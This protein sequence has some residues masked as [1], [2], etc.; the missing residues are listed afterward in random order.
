[1]RTTS[2]R[3]L[4]LLAGSALVV[5]LGTAGPAVADP[6]G[7]IIPVDCDGTTYM[8]AVS[9]NGQFTPGHDTSSTAMLI[10]VSFGDF[11]G[12]ITDE[13]G[14]VLDTFVEPGGAK[15]PAKN[16]EVNCTFSFTETFEDPELGTLTFTGSGSAQ[17]F[18]TPRR[19]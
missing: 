2:A 12:T 8:V 17:G 4:A 10:P 6:K 19:R 5:T 13:E 3:G 18:I 1:M 14:N 11:T 7:E 16:A 15:G 9:G